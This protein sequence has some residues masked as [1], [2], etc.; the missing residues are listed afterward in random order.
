MLSTRSGE[1]ARR[2][3]GED[4]AKEDERPTGMSVRRSRV[5]ELPVAVRDGPPTATRRREAWIRKLHGV[6]RGVSAGKSQIPLR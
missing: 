1:T 5:T 3:I 6:H 2:I 4:K